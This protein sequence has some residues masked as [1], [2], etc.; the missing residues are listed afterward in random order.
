MNKATYDLGAPDWLSLVARATLGLGV[1]SWSLP[2]GAQITL[3]KLFSFKGK[4]D[5]KTM[6]INMFFR[7]YRK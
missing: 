7:K 2:L 5:L 4:K 3:K 1:M 6:F